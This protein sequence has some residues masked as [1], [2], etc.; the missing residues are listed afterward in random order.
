MKNL[1]SS[2]STA[3]YLAG[4]QALQA[5]GIP[6]SF[7]EAASLTL[8]PGE[9][10]V[11]RCSAKPA[12][13]NQKANPKTG[14]YLSKSSG[15]G[16]VAAFFP[17]DPDL[18]RLQ[19]NVPIGHHKKDRLKIEQGQ[20]K[21]IELKVTLLDLLRRTEANG[22]LEIH[23]YDAASGLLSF[24]YKNGCGPKKNC[25]LQSNDPELNISVEYAINLKEAKDLAIHYSRPWDKPENLLV[26][27]TVPNELKNHF[28]LAQFQELLEKGYILNYAKHIE[29]KPSPFKPVLVF[30]DYAIQKKGSSSVELL[31]VTGDV[32]ELLV[33]YPAKLPRYAGQV[34]QTFDADGLPDTLGKVRLLRATKQYFEEIKETYLKGNSGLLD[35]PY[36]NSIDA[37][38]YLKKIFQGTFEELFS[39]HD[40]Q[41]ANFAL[42]RAGR[43]TPH[44]FLYNII[45]NQV[46]SQYPD[47]N[48]HNLYQ[49]G[50]DNRSPYNP[51][52]L[53]APSLTLRR[54]LLKGELETIYCPS[55]HSLLKNV[56]LDPTYLKNCCFH[57]NPR[58]PMDKFMPVIEKQLK[59]QAQSIF[60]ETYHVYLNYRKV[61]DFEKWTSQQPTYQEPSKFNSSFKDILPCLEVLKNYNQNIPFRTKEL[62]QAY[63]LLLNSKQEGHL[64]PN[65]AIQGAIRVFKKHS[66]PLPDELARSNTSLALKLPEPPILQRSS[67]SLLWHSFKDPSLPFFEK[68]S[69]N[70]KSEPPPSHR[71]RKDD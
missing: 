71:P 31:P 39:P 60:P 45:T 41:S 24:R 2:D 58:W 59:F 62:L 35:H 42:E 15:H 52:P 70:E 43:I 49:H 33:G 48:I 10:V 51:S 64:Y 8:N 37:S 28:N 53:D 9:F 68:E 12:A 1:A 30:A 6:P 38:I 50:A 54:N 13:Y 40:N 26:A 27:K 69:Y 25:R 63:E 44:E 14:L 23:A 18:T 21:S 66:Q 34:F 20:Q 65:K 36:L 7:A 19:N 17:L 22:D 47:V 46:Y 16:A 57:I 29:E 56:L 32:D 11:L 5:A 55:L 67:P 4:E 61:L 3:E